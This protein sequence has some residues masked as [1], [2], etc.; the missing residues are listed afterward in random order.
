[1]IHL[2]AMPVIWDRQPHPLGFAIN[3]KSANRSWR[4]ALDADYEK[5]FAGKRSSSTRRR[6][7]RRDKKLENSANIRFG[8]PD[9]N[10]A[11]RTVIHTM[12]EHQRQ[13][14]GK[15]GIIR[16]FTEKQRDFLYHLS[17]ARNT[18]GEAV[19]LPYFLELDGELAA[20]MLGGY[21]D[22][23]Y[24]AM[25]SSL[26]PSRQYYHLSPGDYAL[27]ATI[28]DTC[29]K[30]YSWFD[31]AAGDFDYKKNWAS[32]VVDLGENI[33]AVS[34]KGQLWA[35]GM[36]FRVFVKRWIK[37]NPGAFELAKSLRRLL[38]SRN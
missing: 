1:A 37:N 10:K 2:N 17:Q 4:C 16:L 9:S 27:R 34:L 11:A 36:R 22:G 5:L 28:K 18:K 15:S 8:L 30:G 23:T 13:R 25:I 7:K 12:L 3:T 26:F 21:F 24:W 38:F 6:I 35:A 31:F 19:L 14:L 29:Q 32:E 33:S 20:V